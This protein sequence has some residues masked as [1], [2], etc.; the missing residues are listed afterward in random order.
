VVGGA[1]PL[2]MGRHTRV[3]EAGERPRTGNVTRD[4]VPVVRIDYPR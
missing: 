2:S 1:H 4:T 3:G